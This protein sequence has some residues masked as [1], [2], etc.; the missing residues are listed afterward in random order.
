MTYRFL[1]LFFLFCTL[2]N[3]VLSATYYSQVG[4]DKYVNEQFFKNKKNGVFVDIG[5]YDG[6]TGSNSLFFEKE[7]EWTG[8]CVEPM[9]ESYEKL[10][11]ERRCSCIQGAVALTRKKSEFLQIPDYA[12]QLSGLIDNYHP[13]H[14]QKI[15]HCEKLYGNPAKIIEV[16]CY[17]FN[18]LMD[19]FGIT[20]IDFLSVDTEGNEYEI[21]SSIDW[22]KY[23]IDVIT[24]ENNYNDPRF[25]S[26][27]E[28]KGFELATHIWPDAIYVNKAFKATL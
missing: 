8:L 18:E 9:P 13:T 20:H 17:P 5:S 4:Q 15:R 7:L 25:Q 10:K 27:L 22:E 2:T 16:E 14:L 11:K 12:D 21:L 28:S 19:K 24:V 6:V 23:S 3:P 1:T 26:F